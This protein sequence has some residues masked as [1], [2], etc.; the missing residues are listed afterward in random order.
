MG[1]D[2]AD[3]RAMAPPIWAA[4]ALGNV[5]AIAGYRAVNWT[6]LVPV[7]P[8]GRTRPAPLLRQL[9]EPS[10]GGLEPAGVDVE[11]PKVFV[12]ADV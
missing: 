6:G 3:V 9:H 7:E 10:E 1:P 12:E 2:Y 8:P 11:V 4:H 5:R